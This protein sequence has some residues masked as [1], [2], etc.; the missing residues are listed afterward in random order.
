MNENTN[1]T[2]ISF[3]PFKFDTKY[4][5]NYI[6]FISRN[7]FMESLSDEV[8]ACAANEITKYD[9]IG[10]FPANSILYEIY[11]WINTQIKNV[12]GLENAL[13]FSFVYHRIR[14]EIIGRFVNNYI[15]KG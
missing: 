2:D 11:K 5:E 12:P 9:S 4:C 14:E 8:L 15:K 1:N 7:K 10:V 6:P 3:E 13:S